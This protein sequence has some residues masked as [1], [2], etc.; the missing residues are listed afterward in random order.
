MFIAG[1]DIQIS[2]I[3]FGVI[4]YNFHADI[5]NKMGHIV[6]LCEVPLLEGMGWC[7]FVRL[8]SASLLF[9]NNPGFLDDGIYILYAL[10]NA[11]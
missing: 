10:I 9:I 5:C 1:N 4:I 8:L 11:L 7:A 6:I 3:L 2:K